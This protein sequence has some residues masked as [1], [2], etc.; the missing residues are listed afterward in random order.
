MNIPQNSYPL[1]WPQGWKRTS[2]VYRVSARF[3][4][5]TLG[6][7]C[8]EA[9][10]EVRRLAGYTASERTIISTNIKPRLDGR[11]YANQ[12]QPQD[13]GVAV[14]FI[15]ANKPRVIACDKWSKV[16]DNLWA[17]V[18][19]IEALRGQDRWG[20]GSLERAFAGYTAIPEKTGGLSWW[21]TLGVA[22]NASEEMVRDAYHAKAKIYHPDSGTEPDAEKMI[23]VNLAYQM[24]TSQKI[25]E[26]V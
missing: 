11:P 26:P 19:H 10:A 8:D 16:E 15:Y 2:P 20:C 4:N 18:K 12:G 23:E 14:Y 6:K 21:E 3:K 22:M 7:C 13:P 25:V 1:T 5:N 24:A 9:F 17:I